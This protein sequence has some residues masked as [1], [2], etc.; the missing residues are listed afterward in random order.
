MIGIF[1]GSFDPLHRG[2]IN[3][4]L[5]VG[6][7]LNLSQVICIPAHQTP[8]RPM[9][10]GPTPAERLEMTKEGLKPQSY[11][12]TVDDREVRRG[13][14]SYTV[15]TLESLRQDYPD[16]ELFLIIGMDQFVNFSQWRDY[17]KI[18]KLTHLAVTSRPDF[19]FPQG[20][21]DLP[22]DLQ[23]K[24]DVFDGKEAL[25]H[26]G[27]KIVFVQLQDVAVSATEIRRRYRQNLPTAKFVTPEVDAYIREKGLYQAGQSKVDNFE[28]FTQ[29]CMAVLENRN[30]I[31]IQG[32]DLREAQSLSEYTLVCSGTSTRH[33]SS[34]AE[35][36]IK[37]VKE[38]YGLWP[39]NVEGQKEG[40][41]VVIDYG[42]LIVHVFYDF[43]RL[44]YRLEELWQAQKGVKALTFQSPLPQSSV[45]TQR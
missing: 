36:V 40:R 38:E 11:L 42:S 28:N 19:E 27:S 13:G 24:V 12:I 29:F 31:N 1:G 21:E 25:L 5:S 3:S 35:A 6:H 9:T 37:A 33:A 26:N 41:W 18:L 14:I 39:L 4:M 7:A 16:E 30:G 17:E 20:L 2:H 44:E 15:D 32:F 8:N 10:E 34:L 22:V 43:V 23:D 45:I